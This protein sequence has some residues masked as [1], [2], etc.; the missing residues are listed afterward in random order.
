MGA[1]VLSHAGWLGPEKQWPTQSTETYK[2][3]LATYIP[4]HLSFKVVTGQ[5][6]PPPLPPLQRYLS[7][8][9]PPLFADRS[10][11]ELDS[12]SVKD[13]GS[14]I[15]YL[16]KII[17]LVGI[18]SGHDIDVRPSKVVAGLEPEGTN[19]LLT[20]RRRGGWEGKTCS[21]GRDVCL[22]VGYGAPPTWRNRTSAYH[23]K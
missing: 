6:S 3:N 23:N 15:A 8:H 10:G 9:V 7:R 17:A 21:R 4:V 13:K 18:C 16:D 1:R 2:P 19:A 12:G 5:S 20:V 22:G 14:K 11:E